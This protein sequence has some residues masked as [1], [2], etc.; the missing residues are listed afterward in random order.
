VEGLL[1]RA[2]GDNDVLVWL[3]RFKLECASALKE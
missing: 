3:P 1:K 2:R